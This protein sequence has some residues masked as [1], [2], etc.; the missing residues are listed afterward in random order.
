MTDDAP[1]RAWRTADTT[2]EWWPGLPQRVGG[3][4][5]DAGVDLTQR[6]SGG[7]DRVRAT[8]PI[9]NAHRV[10]PGQHHDVDHPVPVTATLRWETGDEELD[11]LAL[12]WTTALVRVRIADLRCMTGAVWLPASDV[13]RR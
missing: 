7:M 12:E 13:R 11:T 5:E 8:V 6:V 2:S 4:S 10:P 1:N 9:L 3:G